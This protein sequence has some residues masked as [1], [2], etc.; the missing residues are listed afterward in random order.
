MTG[1]RQ[2]KR[3]MHSDLGVLPLRVT[4]HGKHM[5]RLGYVNMEAFCQKRDGENLSKLS[6]F[7]AHRWDSMI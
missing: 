3:V 4:A 5:A 2:V 1:R 6:A 7:W